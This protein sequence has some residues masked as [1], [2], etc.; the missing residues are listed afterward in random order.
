MLAVERAGFIMN[1]LSKKKIVL[2]AEL[3]K[4]LKVSEE[5]VRKDLEKLE[6]QGKLQKVHGGA[7]LNEGY[8]NETPVSVRA[9]IFQEVKE[10]L[11]FSCMQ[12]IEEKETIFLDCSTTIY[13]L[14]KQLVNYEKKLTVVT[15][16][17][18]SAE[19]L[20]ANPNIRL[21]LLGG[22]LNREAAAFDGYTVFEALERY[23]IDKAF[24]SPS[25]LDGKFGMT[26]YTQ[27]QADLRRKVLQESGQCICVSDE[28]KI[29]KKGTYIV[30][31]VEKISH[32]I[33]ENPLQEEDEDLKR[34]IN[35]FQIHVITCRKK[36][37][38]E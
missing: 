26:D 38:N 16:S 35:E 12:F 4:E 32:L 7:Y 29:G 25:G 11:A 6:K 37:K 2:V 22:E 5:T 14:A 23:H 36:G 1:E 31:G 3:S 15:N 9:E 34:K 33:L 8:S 10:N 13:H 28:T 18:M 19:K 20:S 21:I 30:G 17:L 24:L 27:E